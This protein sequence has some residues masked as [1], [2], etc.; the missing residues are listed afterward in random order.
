MDMHVPKDPE[1]FI[2]ILWIASYTTKIR[3]SSQERTTTF[4]T[5][6]RLACG[7]PSATRQMLTSRIVPSLSACVRDDVY[8]G[9][10]NRSRQHG[11]RQSSYEGGSSG[12]PRRPPGRTC[13]AV[14]ANSSS[15]LEDGQIEGVRMLN[16]RRLSVS[17]PH[18][19]SL[20]LLSLHSLRSCWCLS[21]LSFRPVQL[22]HR[23][24]TR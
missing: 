22:S 13:R 20:A 2:R 23:V 9:R 19:L 8:L 12:S 6:H 21:F 4:H 24:K 15:E 3:M 1:W 16:P 17:H 10:G 14:R 5:R 11:L 7:L 18:F